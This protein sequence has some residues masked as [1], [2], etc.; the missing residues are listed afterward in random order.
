MTRR[1]LLVGAVLSVTAVVSYFAWPFFDWLVLVQ[2]RAAMRAHESLPS[3]T[4]KP[5]Q[6]VYCRMQECDYR[7]PLPD[8]VNV[9]A[10]DL[11]QGGADSIKGAIYVTTS[12]G[13]PMDWQAYAEVL[14]RHHFNVMPHY[15][16]EA[17]PPWVGAPKRNHPTGYAIPFAAGGEDG[18]WVAVDTIDHT[19]KI[20]FSYFGD[21]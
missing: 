9:A 15:A 2:I 13:G 21:Y 5:G 7:F 16:T 6:T 14:R 10:I 17:D 3:V 19:N 11:V 8:G 18:G 20:A 12:N 1:N 4:I